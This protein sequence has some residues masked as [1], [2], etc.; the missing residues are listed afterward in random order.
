MPEYQMQYCD[1]K[2]EDAVNADLEQYDISAVP[3]SKIEMLRLLARTLDAT[4][5]ARDIAPLT[6]RFSE[7]LREIRA[8]INETQGQRSEIDD[9][10]AQRKRMRQTG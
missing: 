2:M 5:S 7:T 1:T 6:K 8:E 9:M 4:T 3:A 10:L